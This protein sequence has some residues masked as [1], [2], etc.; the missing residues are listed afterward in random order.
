M[1]FGCNLCASPGEMSN[2]ITTSGKSKI[3]LE[4]GWKL[5]FLLHRSINFDR[6]IENMR[7]F[8]GILS[9]RMKMGFK[10]NLTLTMI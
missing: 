2:S 4:L 10:V 9:I 5:D 7:I 8:S 1:H 3:K 6:G